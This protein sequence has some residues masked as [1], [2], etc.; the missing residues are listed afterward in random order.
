MNNAIPEP[1]TRLIDAFSRLPGVGPKT[2]ARLTYY[3]LRQ[4]E[5]ISITLADALRDLKALTRLC[6]VC[7][8]ITVNDPCMI[9]SNTQRDQNVICVVE[10]PLDVLAIE[11][12]GSYHGVYHVLHGAINY[13]NGV[14]VENLKIRELVERVDQGGVQEVIIATNPSFEGEATANFIQKELVGKGLRMTRLARGLPVGGDIEYADSV[15]LTR[16]L[17]GRSE[18]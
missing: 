13:V 1:I 4:P 14:G 9:C 10:E 2:A 18:I 7:Y 5:E 16:A 8:N 12:T 17:Q 6:S 15:T 11:R 3:L